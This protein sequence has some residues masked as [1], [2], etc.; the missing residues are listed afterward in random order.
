VGAERPSG[1]AS[2][3]VVVEPRAG[4]KATAAQHH[5]KEAGPHTISPTDSGQST[6]TAAIAATP[7]VAGARVSS[8]GRTSTRIDFNLKA[9]NY[10]LLCA[11]PLNTKKKDKDCHVALLIKIVNTNQNTKHVYKNIFLSLIRL[12][13]HKP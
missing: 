4:A 8:L 13:C 6:T 12:I 11:T 10:P 3:G 1:A 7:A 5:Q 9:L 2:P